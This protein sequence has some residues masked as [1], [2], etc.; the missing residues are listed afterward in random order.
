[1]TSSGSEDKNDRIV[2]LLAKALDLDPGDIHEDLSRESS[3]YWDSLGHLRVCMAIESEFGIKLT[4]E[5][6]EAIQNFAD[7]VKIASND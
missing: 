4:V 3:N 7:L 5:Q 1:L 2:A 6:M